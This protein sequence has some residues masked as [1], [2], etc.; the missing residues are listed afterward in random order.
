MK[1]R[2]RITKSHRN[3]NNEDPAEHNYTDIQN[4]QITRRT[5]QSKASM[6]YKQAHTNQTY[7]N[8]NISK[9]SR[10][11]IH[12]TYMSYNQIRKSEDIQA[13]QISTGK[14]KQLINKWAWLFTQ[15][16]TLS[17]KHNQYHNSGSTNSSQHMAVTR[18]K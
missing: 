10:R 8:W 12:T 14:R 15:V 4:E 6:T 7:K 9:H 5:K 16:K 17:W 13:K 2:E 18:N 3:E 1:Q 11:C